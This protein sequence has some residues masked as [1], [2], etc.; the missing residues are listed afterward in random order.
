MSRS[1]TLPRS[2]KNS[3]STVGSNPPL[4]KTNLWSAAPTSTIRASPPS[5]P[6]MRYTAAKIAPPTS[7]TT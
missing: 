2:T 6:R 1:N 7:T 5:I 4:A 3:T